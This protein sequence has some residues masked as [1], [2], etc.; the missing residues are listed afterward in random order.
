MKD[1]KI[2]LFD[3]FGLFAKD[4]FVEFFNRRYGKDGPRLKDHFC[5]G[6]D[7]GKCDKDELFQQMEGELSLDKELIANELKRI[8]TPIQEMIELAKKCKRRHPV[9]LLSNC[10]KGM[11]EFIFDGTPFSECFDGEFRSYDLGLI[12]PGREIYDFVMKSLSPIDEI[13]F[14]DDN[15]ANLIEAKNA[16]I[17]AIL[18]KDVSSCEKELVAR[19]LL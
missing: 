16:G 9:Y 12:K 14:F 10:I 4:P 1:D 18:F 7:L 15:P 2:I 6:A 17:E 11:I 8:S 5:M 19:G 3:C 13:Y